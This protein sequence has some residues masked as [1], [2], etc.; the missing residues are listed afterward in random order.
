MLAADI[1]IIFFD[2]KA[3]NIKIFKI[4]KTIF[5]ILVMSVAVYALIP[6]KSK[7]ID[8]QPYSEIETFKIDK[9]E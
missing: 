1:Y 8:W 2:K 7:A 6:N 9:K 4:F 5:S 3:N